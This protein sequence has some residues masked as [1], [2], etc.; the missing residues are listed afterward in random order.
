[1]LGAPSNLYVGVIYV[2]FF[3]LPMKGISLL[4]L[5]SGSSGREPEHGEVPKAARRGCK[6]SFEPR[7]R[8][9]ACMGAKW[10]C[11]GAKRALDGAKDSEKAGPV[12]S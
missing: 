3:S 5:Q 8:K 10:A 4:G 9:W 2:L 7:E 11:T 1:M 12:R 6:R